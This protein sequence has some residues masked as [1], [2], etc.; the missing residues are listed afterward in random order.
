RSN[1]PADQKAGRGADLFFNR[2]FL[3]V[4]VKGTFPDELVQI[5]RDHSMLPS[6]ETMDEKLLQENTVDILGVNYYQP[7]RV[8]AKEYMPHPDAPLMPEHFFDFYD[9]P[10]KKMNP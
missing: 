8:K 7:R 6:T 5:L 10:G 4:S 2:S 9:M 1:H 3:D